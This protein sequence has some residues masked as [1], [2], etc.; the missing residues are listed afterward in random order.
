MFWSLLENLNRGSSSW[1]VSG[2]KSPTYHC[3]FCQTFQKANFGNFGVLEGHSGL[4]LMSQYQSCVPEKCIVVIDLF[5]NFEA[6]LRKCYHATMNNP[7]LTFFAKLTQ[8]WFNVIILTSRRCCKFDFSVWTLHPTFS[9][10]HRWHILIEAKLPQ[11]CKLDIVV[12]TLWRRRFEYNIHSILWVEPTIQRW[13]KVG[14]T[15]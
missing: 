8:P 15:V 14:P 1:K 7:H 12:S 2:C 4:N 6:K 5:Y 3:S 10:Q 13:S 11:R 9:L